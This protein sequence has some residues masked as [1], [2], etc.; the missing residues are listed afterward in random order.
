MF[1]SFKEMPTLLKFI[2][3]HALICLMFFV[4]SI[5][6]NMPI[7]FNGEDATVKEVWEAG[8]GLHLVAIGIIMPICGV[9]FLKRSKYSRPLYL[10]ATFIGLVLPGLVQG[11]IELLLFG[12]IF[13]SMVLWYLYFKESVREFYNPITKQCY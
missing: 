5:R 4:I 12:V 9:L 10:I 3:A 2:T 1:S 6:P 13:F 8:Y 11:Q 7:T